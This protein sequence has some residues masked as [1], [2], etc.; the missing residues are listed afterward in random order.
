LGDTTEGAI[1]VMAEKAGYDFK[2]IREQYKRLDERPFD[3]D[4]K[5]MSTVHEIHGGKT[6]FTKGAPESVL[7]ICTNELHN[8]KVRKLTK[9]RRSEF[10]Q[11]TDNMAH[12]GY[13]TLAF[14][15][16]TDNKIEEDMIFLGIVGIRDK[17]RQ[18][19]KD[20]VAVTKQAGIRVI[21]ITGDH[22][23]TAGAIGKEL[24]IIKN[25]SEAINC[26]ELDEMSDSEFI[27]TVTRVSV[28]ARASPEHKTRIVSG[29]QKKGEIVAM[30]GDGVNDAPALKMADIG[31]AMG[32]TGTDVSKE[33]SDMIITDDNFASIVAAVEEGRGIYD[34]IRKVLLFLLSCNMSEVLFILFAI[35]FGWPA[36]LLALQILWINLV[37][38][39]FPALALDTE[40][41]EP[42]IMKRK[43]R[44]PK[45][46]AITKDMGISIG[47]SAIIITI[48]SLFMFW[49][50]LPRG[51][52]Y[53]RTMALTT[54]IMFQMWT[55]IAYRSTTHT[56]SEIGWFSNPRLLGAIALSIFL[57]LPLIYIPQVQAVFGTTYLGG[58]EWLEIILLSCTGL[59]VIEIWEWVNRKYMKYGIG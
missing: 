45:E 24:G 56:M 40:P 19:A 21:M 47:I 49:Y 6:V 8:G 52:E 10:Y 53:A 15:F 39:S 31:V 27:K 2:K 44:D 46:R 11:L 41:K 35:L 23:Q 29:L 37:T 4:R 59:I 43:P 28:Y 42:G 18:E 17:I 30:T 48:G 26:A 12:Y 13:R 14:S 1:I 16:S 25:E 32:I 54:M 3:A 55:A 36:P 22:K 7:E 33:S 38:D 57:M 34:N 58:L 51:I 50:T 5:M 9:D 20:A